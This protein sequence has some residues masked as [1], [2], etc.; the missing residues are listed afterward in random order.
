MPRDQLES[1][2]QEV[3]RFITGIFNFLRTFSRMVMPVFG[4]TIPAMESVVKHSQP[5]TC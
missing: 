3:A 1:K 4:A 2:R 5:T